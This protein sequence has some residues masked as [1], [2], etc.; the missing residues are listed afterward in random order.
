[1]RITVDE[2]LAEARRSLKRFGAAEAAAAAQAGALII[3]TRQ[4]TDR[5]RLGVIAGSVHIPR[6]V[7]EW[8]CDPSYGM[9]NPEIMSFDQHLIVVCN[10]GF[11]SSLAARNLQLIGYRHATDLIGGVEAWIAAGLPVQAPAAIDP[12]VLDGRWHRDPPLM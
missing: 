10:E 2:L 8:A 11:S 12:S 7:L 6:T 5:S 9:L 4:H 3:D 1:M